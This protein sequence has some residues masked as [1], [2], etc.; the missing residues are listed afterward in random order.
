MTIVNTKSLAE[1]VDRVDEAFFFGSSISGA[2]REEAAQWIASRQGL[3][4]SYAGMFAPTER[5]FKEGVRVFTG[6][7]MRSRA[8]TAHILGE[9]ACRALI[10]L[11]VHTTNVEKALANASAGMMHSLKKRGDRPT[12][13][14]SGTYCCGTCSASLWRHLAVGGLENPERLLAA[15][16]KTLKAHRLGTGRWKRFPFYYTLLALS[17]IDLPS[18]VQELGYAA[19]SCERLLKRSPKNGKYDFRRRVL[20]ERILEMCSR[21]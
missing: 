13:Q 11:E 17:E 21:Q 7:R 10:L 16:L 12:A 1:M 4:G 3:P 5:D 15:G 19:P 18:A 14:T 20:A 9:E 6:E 2:Q 8:G